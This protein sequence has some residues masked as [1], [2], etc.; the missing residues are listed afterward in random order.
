MIIQGTAFAVFPRLAFNTVDNA[1]E[2]FFQ[3]LWIRL[4]GD[5]DAIL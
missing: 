2:P 1:E 3:G 5:H 4:F